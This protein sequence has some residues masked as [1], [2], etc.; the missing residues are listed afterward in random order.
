MVWIDGKAMGMND[1]NRSQILRQIPASSIESIEVMN[2]PASKYGTEGTAGIINIRLRQD[3]RHGYYGNAEMNVDS[4]GSVNINANINYNT[5]KFESFAGL[6]LKS[7]HEP[8]G[9][10]SFRKYADGTTLL[11]NGKQKKHENSIF[12]RLGTNYRPDEKN[13]IYIS[14]VGTS[15]HKWG[16]IET[17]HLS[18]IPGLWNKDINNLKEKGNNIG[19]NILAGYKHFFQTDNFIDFN[20]SYN[21]WQAKNNNLVE[22]TA[23]FASSPGESDDTATSWQKSLQD[24]TISNWEIALDYTNLLLPWL[25]L[26]TGIKANLNHE[27]RPASYE[28]GPTETE[29]T[30]IQELLYRF[31]YDTDIYALYINFSGKHRN[32][33]YGAGLRGEAWQIRTRSLSY[34]EI[35]DKTPMFK[36]ND[37]ALFPSASVGWEFLSD[38]ELKLTYSRRIRR[39]FGPQLNTF[40]NISDPSEVHIGNPTIMP[41]Y[42]NSL[43]LGYIKTW[44]NCTLSA[45]A[46]MQEN[47][48]IISHV[49]FLAPMAS[50]PE[51][52][53]MYYGHANVGNMINTGVEIIS[54]NILFKRLTLTTTLN[55]YNSHLKAWKAEYPLH[56]YLYPISG[57]H[58]N[59]LVWKISCMASVKLPWDM[60]LQ[61]TGRY[62]SRSITPQGIERSGWDVE[63]GLKKNLGNW[64]FSLICKDIFDSQKGRDVLYGNGYTQSI[65]KW[66][67]GRTLR[68]GI[69]YN[70]GKS[71][72]TE[73]CMHNHVNTGG[74]GDSDHHH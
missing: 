40:E 13:V 24:V 16:S 49:S 59:R 11:S 62:E 53:T 73:E 8:G 34:G 14:A 45:S 74:Y 48:D 23:F 43:E 5:G 50:D 18:T 37:I 1:D 66:K 65:S 38:N 57:P 26:E 54:R 55:L 4:R 17:T 72:H 67:T 70:F 2:N 27:N 60:S 63:A 35:N 19:V 28:G 44:R 20:A 51:I 69:A 47:S 33:T 7:Q 3:D 21:F 12:L 36:K 30:P 64:S 46:Y 29:L 31:H 9:S 58:Q 42:S 41:E 15:G 10:E 32:I 39:P 61:A 71:L 56:G 22:D 25:K 6:G 68:L 52:N